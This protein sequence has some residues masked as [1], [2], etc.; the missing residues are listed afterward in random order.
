ALLGVEDPERRRLGRA[1]DDHLRFVS[2]GGLGAGE[3]RRPRRAR[4]DGRSCPP[5]L[6]GELPW[7]RRLDEGARAALGALP[8]VAPH[9][10]TP[11]PRVRCAAEIC[12][13]CS[14]GTP[15]TAANSGQ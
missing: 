6:V 2:E 8:V 11:R 12:A 15:A 7:P 1:A 10:A 5:L 4:P 13:T 3:R 9:G 14:A